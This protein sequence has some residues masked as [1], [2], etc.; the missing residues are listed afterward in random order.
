MSRVNDHI[1]QWR[2]VTLVLLL[3]ALL[4][5]WLFD[6]VNVPVEYPCS[7]PYIR[8]EGDFCGMPHSGMWLVATFVS[9][10]GRGAIAGE[11]SLVETGRALLSSLIPFILVMPVLSA[12][13]LIWRGNNNI[14]LRVINVV[15]WG[16]A[17]TL[18]W[19]MILMQ[20]PSGILPL[21]FWGLWLYGG[22]TTANFAVEAIALFGR[23]RREQ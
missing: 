17:A 9:G 18:S 12:L 11:F 23:G 8:L 1:Q 2:L 20:T 19:F 7:A 3:V 5:P 21:Q 13:I 6:R 4:G 15:I 14:L 22:V 16:L 10:F